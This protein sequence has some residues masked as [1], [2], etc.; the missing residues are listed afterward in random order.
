MVLFICK[1]LYSR[2]PHIKL[3]IVLLYINVSLYELPSETE[4]FIIIIIIIF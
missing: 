3:F 4:V 2:R 1:Y